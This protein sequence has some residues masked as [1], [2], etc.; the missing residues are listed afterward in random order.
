MKLTI[1]EVA[2]I[3]RKHPQSIYR[4]VRTNYKG[5]R[6]ICEQLDKGATILIEE[7]NLESWLKRRSNELAKKKVLS[8]QEYKL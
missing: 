1:R 4:W 3:L 7:S 5:I 6:E 2:K 8:S